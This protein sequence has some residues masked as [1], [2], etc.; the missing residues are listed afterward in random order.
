MVFRTIR[1]RAIP[2]LLALSLMTGG[3]ALAQGAGTP[4]AAIAPVSDAEAAKF[5]AANRKVTE[6]AN[7][8]S[9][10]LKGAAS[11]AD[12]A[13]ILAKGEQQMVA[14]IQ[15][16]GITPKRYTEIIQLAETDQATLD[17]LRAE[18]DG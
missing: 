3:A 14:A 13:A 15:A 11:E 10:Q 7:T 17:R 4:P 18:Y 16:E 1:T 5:V 8:L 6:V 2:A 9:A 12:A